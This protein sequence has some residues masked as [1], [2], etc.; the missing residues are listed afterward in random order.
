MSPTKLLLSAAFAFWVTVSHAE[1][2]I[3]WKLDELRGRGEHSRVVTLLEHLRK[4]NAVPE[5]LEE[6]LDLELAQAHR[7]TIKTARS[8]EQRLDRLANAIG[9]YEEFLK[10]QPEHESAQQARHDLATLF[11]QRAR[12]QADRAKTSLAPPQRFELLRIADDDLEQSYEQMSAYRAKI[13][14]TLIGLPKFIDPQA[15]RELYDKRTQLRSEY[16]K[17][18]LYLATAVHERAVLRPKGS[19]VRAKLLEQAIAEYAE[20]YEKYRT[21]L[22]GLY[23]RLWQGRCHTAAGQLEEAEQI[24]LDLMEQ[25]ESQQAFRALRTQVLIEAAKAWANPDRPRPEEIVK[26]AASWV[27]Q[28]TPIDQRQKDWSSLVYHLAWAHLQLADADDATKDAHIE[29]ADWACRQCISIDGEFRL[30]AAK[31]LRHVPKK[32]VDESRRNRLY[33][34]FDQAYDLGRQSLSEYASTVSLIEGLKWLR[35][36][37]DDTGWEFI[38]RKPSSAAEFD[39]TI[40][41]LQNDAK[42]SLAD[43][44]DYFV[45]ALLLAKD[46]DA[47]PFVSQATYYL[48]YAYYAG[49][50]F[51]EAAKAGEAL[52]REDA[53]QMAS[54]EAARIALASRVKLFNTADDDAREKEADALLKTASSIAE[55]WPDK[56]VADEARQTAVRALALNDRFAAAQETLDKMPPD[57]AARKSAELFLGCALWNHA[58]ELDRELK[59]LEN[60]TPPT[61]NTVLRERQASRNE[62]RNTASSL[63][64]NNNTEPADDGPDGRLG[65]MGQLLRA[66]IYLDFDQPKLAAKCLP[67]DGPTLSWA[68]KSTDGGEANLAW[69]ILKTAATAHQLAGNT[70][71][72]VALR[73]LTANAPEN[74]DTTKLEWGWDIDEKSLQPT[75]PR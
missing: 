67:I 27:E 29:R 53:P 15:D 45:T 12:Y 43:A 74:V 13:R 64:V 14:Q 49:E 51:G 54:I 18:L 73:E 2:D 22:A 20:V 23:A 55:A 41:E 68:R 56:P 17:A 61:P 48:V 75:V 34:D 7:E 71:A 11:F 46:D 39:E 3:Q 37:Q 70:A 25:P 21:R 35:E 6:T 31:L 24:F 10:D 38:E 50:K 8:S 58:E 63:L 30:K 5:S 69:S 40:E 60:A 66:N 65:R 42:K 57:S 36:H 9:A 44:E 4:T 52:I 1:D 28:A 32:N 19:K 72:A 16:L 62:V 47:N 26:H 33:L 59:R